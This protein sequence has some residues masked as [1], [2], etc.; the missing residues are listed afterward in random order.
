MKNKLVSTSGREGKGNIE[1]GQWEIQITECKI[2][3]KDVLY[4]R[5]IANVL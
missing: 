2:D 4:M 5:N 3:Y 1:K